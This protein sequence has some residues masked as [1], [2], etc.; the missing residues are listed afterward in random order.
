MKLDND[1]LQ[2]THV[3]T[4]TVQSQQSDRTNR[5]SITT[6]RDKRETYDAT[7]ICHQREIVNGRDAQQPDHMP[8]PDLM[9]GRSLQKAHWKIQLKHNEAM[10]LNAPCLHMS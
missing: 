4:R 6:K 8:I 7:R 1:K 3:N 5:N 2:W 9:K 10:K